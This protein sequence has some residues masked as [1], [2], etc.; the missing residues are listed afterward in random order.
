[1]AEIESEYIYVCFKNCLHRGCWPRQQYERNQTWCEKPIK[2][3][4]LQRHPVL[5]CILSGQRVTTTLFPRV[6]K[7]AKYMRNSFVMEAGKKRRGDTEEKHHFRLQDPIRREQ[8]LN[9][10]TL[11]V[12]LAIRTAH[13]LST[14]FFKA[15]SMCSQLFSIFNNWTWLSG[16]PYEASGTAS[17]LHLYNQTWLQTHTAGHLADL[18]SLD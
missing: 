7:I 18:T 17:V 2:I 5:Y 4:L 9:K 10:G 16:G 12:W 8:E 1:V 11:K 6:L 3:T 15:R 14:S 13:P